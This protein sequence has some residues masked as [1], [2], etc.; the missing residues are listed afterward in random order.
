MFPL[1]RESSKWNVAPTVLHSLLVNYPWGHFSS[2]P[3][4]KGPYFAAPLTQFKSSVTP[5]YLA[6]YWVQNRY[7]RNLEKISI[8]RAG[9]IGRCWNYFRNPNEL[10]SKYGSTWARFGKDRDFFP[11]FHLQKSVDLVSLSEPRYTEGVEYVSSH[12]KIFL[13]KL[14]IHLPYK[15]TIPFVREKGLLQ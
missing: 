14:N 4:K 5:Q 3:N 6:Q 8:S 1:A 9:E 15:P 2:A 12:K 10:V 11:A 13:K 7:P